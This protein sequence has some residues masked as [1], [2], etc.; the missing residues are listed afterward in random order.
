MTVAPPDLLIFRQR[1]GQVTGLTDPADIGIVGDGRHQRTGGYHE[2]E[3]VLV[4]IGRYTP[5]PTAHIGSTSQDYSARL[6]R[7]RAGLT[8][9]ASGV[10]V[11]DDWPNGGRAAWLRFGNLLAAELR[12]NP[13]LAPLRAINYS[14][15]GRV[16]KRIDREHG[17]LM[18]DSTDTVTTHLHAEWYR[19]TVGRRSAALDRVVDIARTAINP[20]TPAPAGRLEDTMWQGQLPAGDGT[21]IVATPW[22]R[23]TMSLG[24]TMGKAK[25]RVAEHIVNQPPDKAWLITEVTVSDADPH[26]TD[27][28]AR[29]GCDRRDITR[30]PIDAAD[31]LVTPV[32]WLAWVG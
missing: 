30:V 21:A 19:D 20:N 29:T 7:D 6:A 18:V 14:P 1:M 16:K 27:L 2:G 28:P 12:I 26:R 17:W 15:D 9:Y 11:G 5:P 32:V 4:D 25:L 31:K 24:A 23:S 22:D 13:V 8:D 10:D 3:D